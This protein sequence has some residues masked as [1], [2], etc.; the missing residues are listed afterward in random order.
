MPN[1]H[2]LI[3]RKDINGGSEKGKKQR[4]LGKLHIAVSIFLFFFGLA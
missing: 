2:K 4:I 1:A 3:S